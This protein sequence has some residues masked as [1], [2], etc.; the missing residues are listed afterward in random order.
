MKN[1]QSCENLVNINSFVILS[2]RFS[3]LNNDILNLLLPT[4]KSKINFA[5][6]FHYII[7]IISLTLLLTILG[8]FISPLIWILNAILRIQFNFISF[9]AVFINLAFLITIWVL[10]EAKP[11]IVLYED[12]FYLNLYCIL[13]KDWFSIS[14]KF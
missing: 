11:R 4:Q 2:F 6:L 5:M 3:S 10:I 7:L 12:A 9:K 8:H 14:L 1:S 13:H